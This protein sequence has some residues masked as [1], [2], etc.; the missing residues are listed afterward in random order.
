MMSSSMTPRQFRKAGYKGGKDNEF[1]M[2]RSAV[3]HAVSK[4]REEADLLMIHMLKIKLKARIDSFSHVNEC[5]RMMGRLDVIE[6][7]LVEEIAG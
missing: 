2:L 3:H 7:Q 5:T 6:R 1:S 4:S